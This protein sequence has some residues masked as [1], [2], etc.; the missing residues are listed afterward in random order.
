MLMGGEKKEKYQATAF[1]RSWKEN[2]FNVR[3]T[4]IATD[5]LRLFCGLQKEAQRSFITLPDL[6]HY[7]DKVVKRLEMMENGPYP[8]GREEEVLQSVNTYQVSEDEGR[9][10]INLYV[11]TKG[12]DFQAIRQEFVL[13]A[14]HFLAE[15][16]ADEQ[17]E[18][19]QAMMDFA[20]AD[21]A[22][23]MIKAGR[24]LVASLL[25]KDQVADFADEVVGLFVS[26]KSRFQ[27]S[28]STTAKLYELLKNSVHCRTL[29]KLVHAFIITAPHSM[30]TERAIKC[31]NQLKTDLRSTMLRSTVNDRM[32]IALN[33]KGTAHF[34]PMPAVS[35]FLQSKERRMNV[36]DTEI[37]QNREFVR[38]FFAPDNNI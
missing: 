16:M 29:H 27:A 7:R 37:Y 23:Q 31:H 25:G 21:N 22:E 28:D 14:K 15:R 1:L 24:P 4:A 34:N 18:N 6:L 3:F 8:G 12:R 30:Q 2:S 38:K 17:E 35:T 5:I 9:S 13:S 11:T 10:K 20:N 26:A 19:V 33:G 36:P 32:C